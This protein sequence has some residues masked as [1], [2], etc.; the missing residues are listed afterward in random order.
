MTKVTR[1]ARLQQ[2]KAWQLANPDK[3]KANKRKYYLANREKV[4]AR[5]KKWREDNPEQA[6]SLDLQKKYGITIDEWKAMLVAQGGRCAACRTTEPGGKYDEWHTDHDHLT[7]KVRGLLCA[8]CNLTLGN[9]NE[10]IF[11]LDAL[12]EYLRRNA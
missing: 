10:N 11:R 12:A 6:K 3:V 1:E 8:S 5:S 2:V 4:L 7:G 9:A